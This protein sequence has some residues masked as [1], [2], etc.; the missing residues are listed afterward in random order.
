MDGVGWKA[1]KTV[2][3]YQCEE[4]GSRVL[5]AGLLYDTQQCT[6]AAGWMDSGPKGTMAG[7][8]QPSPSTCSTSSM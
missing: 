6:V 3:A 7:L 8:P 5:A 4:A 2:F 1:S